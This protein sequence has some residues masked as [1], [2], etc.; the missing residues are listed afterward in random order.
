MQSHSSQLSSCLLARAAAAAYGGRVDR[1]GVGRPEAHGIRRASIGRGRVAVD[2]RVRVAPAGKC[3]ERAEL[4][5]IRDFARGKNY[6]TFGSWTQLKFERNTFLPMSL[7]D[8]GW[9]P[10][11]P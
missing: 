3:I 4:C 7:P 8:P 2:H 5:C 10:S 1:G 6:V 11:Q 9:L